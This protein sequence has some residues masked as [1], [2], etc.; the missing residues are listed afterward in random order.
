MLT[1]GVYIGSA[2][3]T[4]GIETVTMEFGVSRVAATLGLTLFVAGYGVGPMIWSPMSEI[5]QIGRNPIYIGTL[6]LFVLLQLPTGYAINFGMLL[7]FRFLTGF[8]GS[9]VLATGGASLSD[10]YVPR[11]RAYAIAIWG[12][13]A[14]CG[15]VMGPLVGGFAAEAKDWRWTIWELAW[16]SGFTWLVLFFFLPETSANN[17]LYRRTRRLRKLTGNDRLKCQPEIMGEN[18]TGKDIA[19]MALV[20]PI[21][22]N[23][24]E[25]MVFLLNLYIA[26]VYGL[27][28]IWF[29]SFP[30]VFSQIYGFS[31]GLEGVAFIGILIG[32]VIVLPPFFLYLYK[33]LE[34]QFNEQGEL[35]PEKR[36]PPAFVGGP[37]IV[38]CLFWFGWSAGYTHWIMPI[39][40]SAF[41]SVG[42]VLLFNSVL[43]YLPDAY[44]DYA[45]SVLAGNDFMRSSFGAGFPLFATAMY[46][47]LGVNWASSLLGFL[48]LAFVPIPFFLYKVRCHS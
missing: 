47:K 11:K 18:M 17:I 26:L 46:T 43:N 16:L 3:Y 36:L 5:P 9:P 15:P 12:I 42:A 2:I 35:T 44:P 28:Y 21:T 40:G 48:A 22:L 4:P 10:M 7:A 34:P 6:L 31:L 14:V 13:A 25:P 30:I 1:F 32:A 41:F 38:I 27:L 39:I 19:L 37:A 45:A 8:I 29:E 23:F 33:V 24:L 20:R